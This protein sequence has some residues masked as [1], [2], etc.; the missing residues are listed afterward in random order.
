[1]KVS[2]RDILDILRR[3]ELA[4]DE[5]VPRNIETIKI[6]HPE[7]TNTFASFRFNKIKFCVLFDESVDDDADVVFEQLKICEPN[8]SGV[9]LKNPSDSLKTYAMPFKG[10][11]CYLYEVHSVKKRLDSELALRYPE[12]SR[13]TWQKY[14]KLGYISVNG[15]VVDSPKHEITE[16]DSLE[17]NVPAKTDYSQQ[18]LPIIYI[19]DNVIVVNKPAGVLSHSKGALNDEFTV[20]DF[21]K[22]FSTYNAETNR[23][24]I[25]HRLDRDTSGVMIGARNAE[26]ALILQKQFSDR[27]TKKTYVAILDGIPKLDKANIDLPIDRNPSSPSTFRVDSKGRQALTSYEVIAKSDNKALVNLR[28]MTGRTHQLRVHMKYLGAPIHGDRVYGKPAERLYL[29]ALSLEITIPISNRKT[30]TAPLPK[31]FLQ[32]FPEVKI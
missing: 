16:S 14:I 23:P 1:V 6:M 27:K 20:A 29:H 18:E 19:D 9:L 10:K 3:Y 8:L 21:F 28:P 30:F 4:G 32:E 11:Q 15:K 26:S 12:T 25:V 22:R 24:G 13:N 17:I 5:N 7:P 31:E 2:S